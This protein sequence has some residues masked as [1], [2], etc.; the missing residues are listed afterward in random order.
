MN[1]HIETARKYC[2]ERELSGPEKWEVPE[3]VMTGTGAHVCGEQVPGL[4]PCHLHRHQQEGPE[5]TQPWG[6]G[7]GR[8]P[9]DPTP[10]THSRATGPGCLCPPNLAEPSSCAPAIPLGQQSHPVTP[11]AALTWREA[12]AT[13]PF[14]CS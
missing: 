8:L 7:Q 14:I 9:Q 11:H 13:G 10:S 4:A 12:P 1:P 2:T 6:P 5:Q 3:A